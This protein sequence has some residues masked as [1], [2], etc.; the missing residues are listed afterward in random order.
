MNFDLEKQIEYFDKKYPAMNNANI[1]ENVDNSF[2]AE[3]EE[4]AFYNETYA[5]I[6]KGFIL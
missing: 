6:L 1:Y 2:I 4:N 3:D 5:E